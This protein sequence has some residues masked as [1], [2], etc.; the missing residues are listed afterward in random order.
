[1]SLDK[2]S[3]DKLDNWL[4][5]ALTEHDDYLDDNGFTERVMAA[6]PPEPVLSERKVR[7]WTWGGGVAA[8]ALAALPFPWAE[9]ATALQ[10]TD[11]TTWILVTAVPAMLISVAALAWGFVSFRT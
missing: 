5:T 2:K 9:F 3:P 4:E 1:M 7:L 10:S 11:S 6:L 8:A